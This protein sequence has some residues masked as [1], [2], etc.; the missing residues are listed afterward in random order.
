M[1][2]EKYPSENDYFEYIT[3]NG[4][5]SNANTQLDRTIFYFIISNEAFEGALDRFAQFFI[6]SK[7]SAGSVDREKRQ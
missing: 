4:V 3:K 2:N 5:F 1:G 6:S 7:F